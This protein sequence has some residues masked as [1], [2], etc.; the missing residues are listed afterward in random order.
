MIGISDSSSIVAAAKKMTM[1]V[2]KET[3]IMEDSSAAVSSVDELALV[4]EATPWVRGREGTA[5][6]TNSGYRRSSERDNEID[7]GVSQVELEPWG[8][9]EADGIVEV[10]EKGSAAEGRDWKWVERSGWAVQIILS[11]KFWKINATP[12]NTVKKNHHQ[13][14]NKIQH[15]GR[16]NRA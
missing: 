6:T 7:G 3:M 13:K 9:V 2:K 16:T 10:R 4:V 11:F 8:E 14:S 15:K 1:M 12:S 5:P